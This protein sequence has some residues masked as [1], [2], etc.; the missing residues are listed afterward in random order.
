MGLCRFVV[1]GL[2]D[3]VMRQPH[4]LLILLAAAV[5]AA[6]DEAAAAQAPL[7]DERVVLQTSF[8]DIE[9]GFFPTVAPKSSA[10]CS[11]T[12]LLVA[13]LL[14]G[15]V[16]AALLGRLRGCAAVDAAAVLRPSSLSMPLLA[17]GG[18]A[19]LTSE[20]PATARPLV[21]V[22]A[23]LQALF[24]WWLHHQPHISGR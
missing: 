14:R 7:S 16:G 22:A 15:F 3:G 12:G 10:V 21:G 18:G 24:P 20:M 9:I 6:Q 1:K 23:H 5:V 11:C 4:L 17:H 19:H 13:A 2:A 8:G